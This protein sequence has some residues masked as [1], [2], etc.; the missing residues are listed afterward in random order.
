M[1]PWTSQEP[2][3]V[4]TGLLI[5]GVKGDRLLDDVPFI[6]DKPD[7]EYTFAVRVGFLM[8]GDISAR[9]PNDAR[10]YALLANPGT[11]PL[12]W[13]RFDCQ[14]MRLDSFYC[15]PMYVS[16]H[17]I[18]CLALRKDAKTGR[19]ERIGLAMVCDWERISDNGDIEE[20]DQASVLPWLNSTA[21][22]TLELI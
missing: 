5:N 2:P 14:T 18:P 13:V 11:A 19:V 10:S 4:F 22:T 3:L 7:G 8:G 16:T 6:V 21:R 1:G 9:D 12:G 20:L 15:C 17:G